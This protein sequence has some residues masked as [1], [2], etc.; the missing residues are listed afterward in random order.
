[1]GREKEVEIDDRNNIDYNVRIFIK[2]KKKKMGCG[3]I[4]GNDNETPT[5]IS[6]YEVQLKK[7]LLILTPNSF[8]SSKEIYSH[9]MKNM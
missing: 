4:C 3:A 1:M 7:V 9:F 6:I 8:L 2:N 5:K